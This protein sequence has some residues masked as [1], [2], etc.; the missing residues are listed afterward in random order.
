V[1]ESVHVPHGDEMRRKYV[2]VGGPQRSGTSNVARLENCTGF[3]NTGVLEDEGQYLQDV[4]PTDCA[5]GAPPD[6]DFRFIDARERRQ[7]L[8]ELA[9]LLGQNF[10]KLLVIESL[11]V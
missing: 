7:T 11:S 5:Y 2:F 9:C 4:Y 1:K 6:G 3:K 10:L 8:R